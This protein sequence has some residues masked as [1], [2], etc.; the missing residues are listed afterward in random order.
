M[1]PMF[2]VRP[3]PIHRRGCFATQAI[4]AHTRIAE[5]VG[6][7]ISAAEALRREADPARPFI[8]TFWLDD[9]TVIDGAVNGNA[10]IY[11]NHACDP[12]CYCVQEEG[13]LFFH[14]ARAI[15]PDEE[16][17]FDYAYDYDPETELEPCTCG[18]AR[19]RG[20]INDLPPPENHA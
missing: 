2:E 17:T 20:Y 19:C 18:S 1:T 7:R 10:S 14:A 16:L 9:H 11:I 12:N 13:R 15:Q 8:Y 6:E 5:Y 4:A 3:S